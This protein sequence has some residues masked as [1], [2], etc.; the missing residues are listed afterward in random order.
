VPTATLYRW[1]ANGT[2]TA[3]RVRAHVFISTHAL[4]SFL[5]LHT[6]QG[7]D[8]FNHLPPHVRA[9]AEDHC[10][11]IFRDLTAEVKATPLDYVPG[12]PL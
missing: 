11:Q 7:P 5:A 8:D 6:E 4:A 2:I 10:R 9:E 1:C 3:T 12:E